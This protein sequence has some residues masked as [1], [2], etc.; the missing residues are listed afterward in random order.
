MINKIILLIFLLP[1]LMFYG[2]LIIYGGLT[3]TLF[4][5]IIILTYVFI[6]LFNEVPYGYIY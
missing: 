3:L 4:V 2:F 6:Q 5:G 1:T